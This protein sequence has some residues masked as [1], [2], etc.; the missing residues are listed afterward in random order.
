METAGIYA[1]Q[2]SYLDCAVQIGVASHTVIS[3]SFPETTEEASSTEHEVLDR[4]KHESRNDSRQI[5]SVIEL[6]SVR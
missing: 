1:R 4:Y 5:S 2:S 6:F 3:V